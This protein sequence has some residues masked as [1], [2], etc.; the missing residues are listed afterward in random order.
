VLAV[1]EVKEPER[2]GGGR[3]NARLGD[4]PDGG[5]RL[6][7]GVDCPHRAQGE[8][9][10]LTHALQQPRQEGDSVI[11]VGGDAFAESAAQADELEPISVALVRTQVGD[12]FSQWFLLVGV[13]AVATLTELSCAVIG[14][15]EAVG[16][17]C[18]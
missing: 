18:R 17:C 2:P 9:G 12:E 3:L 10:A 16:D 11:S 4:A 5:K 14:E 6:G 7:A 8:G 15:D 13:G 1:Q